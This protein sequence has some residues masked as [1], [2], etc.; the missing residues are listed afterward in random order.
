MGLEVLRQKVV[1]C[2]KPHECFGCGDN[3]AKGQQADFMVNACDGFA[4]NSYWCMICSTFMASPRDF[5]E[6]EIGQGEM[7]E[8]DGYEEHRAHRQ[9]EEQ[10]A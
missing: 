4:H 3:I 8:I 1:V 6:D 10:H 7:W 9:L 5:P 2:R